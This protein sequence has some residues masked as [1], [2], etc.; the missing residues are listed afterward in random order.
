MEKGGIYSSAFFNLWGNMFFFC[1]YVLAFMHDVEIKISEAKRATLGQASFLTLAFAHNLCE[2]C[3]AH[4]A[5][6]CASCTI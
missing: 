4:T 6:L 2:N 5:W 3:F 1:E